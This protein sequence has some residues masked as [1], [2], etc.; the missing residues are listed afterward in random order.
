M[1]SL[2]LLRLFGAQV[3]PQP[4]ANSRAGFLLESA[5]KRI[6]SVVVREDSVLRGLSLS[7]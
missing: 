6:L 4:F 5:L 7:D 2:S 3:P 1:Y